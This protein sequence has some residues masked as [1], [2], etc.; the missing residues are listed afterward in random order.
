MNCGDGEAIKLKSQACHYS[1]TGSERERERERKRE[2]ER[3]EEKELERELCVI[4]L[5]T[6]MGSRLYKPTAKGSPHTQSPPWLSEKPS[7]LPTFYG[8]NM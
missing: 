6:C 8:E 7:T 3:R 1:H 2:R 5:R 4:L